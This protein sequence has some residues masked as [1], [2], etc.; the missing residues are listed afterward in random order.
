MANKK[1]AFTSGTVAAVEVTLVNAS[2]RYRDCYRQ[3][4][5]LRLLGQAG[6]RQP[7]RPGP[8]QGFLTRL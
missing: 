8:G 1:V 5:P 3:S 4:T 2:T 6:G 7:A